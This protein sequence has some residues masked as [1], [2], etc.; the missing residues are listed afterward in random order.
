[1]NYLTFVFQR[2]NKTILLRVPFPVISVP[3]ADISL[4]FLLSQLELKLVD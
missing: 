3:A 4:L 2:T 1:M